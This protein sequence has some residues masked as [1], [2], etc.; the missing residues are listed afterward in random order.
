MLASITPLGER[1]RQAHWAV[2]VTAFMLGAT[3]AGGAAGGLLGAAGALTLPDGADVRVRLGVLAVALVAAVALDARAERVPG[4]RRQVNEGWLDEYRGWVYGLGY[5]AQLGTGIVTVVSSAATY[6]TLLAA[7]L[8]RDPMGGAAVVGCYGLLR[9]LQPVLTARV[10]SPAAL[11]ALHRRL[12][13]WRA[14]GWR[15]GVALLAGMFVAC[16]VGSAA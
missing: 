14:A 2:T 3:S 8:T 15:F 12:D 4:P 9:G 6:V 10:Q 5:G 13:R 1:G 7:F 16:C 11:I